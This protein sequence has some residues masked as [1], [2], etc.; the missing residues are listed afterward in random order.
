MAQVH[1][2]FKYTVGGVYPTYKGVYMGWFLVALLCVF[3]GTIDGLSKGKNKEVELWKNKQK[4]VL[5]YE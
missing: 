5:Q 3:F 1:R 4:E 2:D